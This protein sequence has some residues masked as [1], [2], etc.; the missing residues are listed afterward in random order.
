MIRIRARDGPDTFYLEM[1]GHAG[2]SDAGNDIVCAAASAIVQTFMGWLGN[3][4]RG[5]YKQS[6]E[7]GRVRLEGKLSANT[8]AVFRSALIGLLQLERQYP[9]HVSVEEIRSER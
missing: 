2:Y 6:A 5:K 4:R 1:T 8:Q 7:S 9:D 3:F